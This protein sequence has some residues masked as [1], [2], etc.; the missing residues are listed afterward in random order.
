MTSCLTTSQPVIPAN[1]RFS[2]INQGKLSFSIIRSYALETNIAK[3]WR[4]KHPTKT[5]S[6]ADPE[7]HAVTEVLQ[8]NSGF[9][10]V[11]ESSDPVD[12]G[13]YVRITLLRDFEASYS[14]QGWCEASA[15]TLVVIPCYGDLS[16]YHADYDLYRNGSLSKH[17]R[18]TYVTKGLGWIG[19]LPL[20]WINLFT[21]SRED[22]LSSTAYQF[23]IDSNRDGLL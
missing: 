23:L 15:M 10:E 22:A 16:V 11:V 9:K 19:L 8:N 4:E 1:E 18:Y 20:I 5:L 2:P 13:I 7:H 12:T 3:E 21:H 14:H 6:S 17:Y